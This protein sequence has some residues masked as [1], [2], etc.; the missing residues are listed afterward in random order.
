M[1]L[2]SSTLASLRFFQVAARFL[3]FKRAALELH[4]TQGAVSQHIKQLEE[5][6]GCKLFYRLP[7]QITLTEEGRQFAAVVER[8]LEQIEQEAK[9][10][11]LARSAIGIRLRA[12]PS[13]ALRWLV[14]RLGDFYAKHPHIKLFIVAAYGY[15]DPAHRDFDL[16]VEMIDGKLPTLQCDTL[17]EEYLVPVC[18]PQYLADHGPLKKPK[19]LA[20]CTLLHDAHAGI[21]PGEDG[22]WRHWLRE[23]GASSVD[24]TSGQFFSLANMSIEAALTHQGVALGRLSLIRDLLDAGQLVLPFKQHVLSPTRYCLVYPKELAGQVGMK[25]VIDWLREQ[26]GE[27]VKPP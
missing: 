17:M 26:A 27:G 4:V 14:P 19:D 9:A 25:A 20:N 16:A 24:S 7:R 15:F 1:F 2:N 11:T 23:V 22:E 10:L 8:A 21:P 18:S 13:F 5:A 12:G 3:S 6:L